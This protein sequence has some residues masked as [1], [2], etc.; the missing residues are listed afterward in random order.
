MDSRKQVMLGYIFMSNYFICFL[1][2][3]QK[4]NNNRNSVLAHSYTI[5]IDS[6]AAPLPPF[7]ITYQTRSLESANSPLE[8]Q[9]QKDK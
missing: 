2:F 8:K 3:L 4:E 6:L 5:S 9:K 7:S 1:F